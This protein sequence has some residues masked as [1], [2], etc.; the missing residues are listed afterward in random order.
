MTFPAGDSGS[1]DV[2]PT[3]GQQA[4]IDS[5]VFGSV[6]AE[7]PDVKSSFESILPEEYKTKEY[8]QN[9][10]KSENPMAAI[11]KSYEGAQSL[12]GQR[13]TL[14]PPDEN[15]TEEQ[16]QNFYKALG[17]PDDVKGYEI[18]APEF[19]PEDKEIGE[20]IVGSRNEAVLTDVKETARKLGVTPAQLQG[21]ASAF[22]MATLKHQKD[23]AAQYMAAERESALAFEDIA[24]KH[25]GANKIQVMERGHKLLMESLPPEFMPYV[26]RM[27]PEGLAVASAIAHS[28]HSKYLKE[29]GGFNT[30]N[31]SR[32]APSDVETLRSE[33]RTL[34]NSDA[35][36]NEWHQN[37]KVIKGKVDAIY[38][39]IKEAGKR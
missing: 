13:Q 5:A 37:H 28:F 26:A 11:L 39:Q 24:T 27:N 38:A 2:T 7:T 9:A 3:T 16:R 19:A 1:A 35:Y 20:Y 18:K 31:A 12:I 6:S 29:D 30:A 34:M 8:V 25:Y 33:A 10:L 22:D 23:E 36:S 4:N 32:P 15:S 17:V 21:L 14:T